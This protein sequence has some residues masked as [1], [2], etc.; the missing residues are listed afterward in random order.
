MERYQIIRGSREG[1]YTVVRKEHPGFMANIS[2][3]DGRMHLV[4]I[5][6]METCELT[7]LQV[8]LNEI[9]FYFKKEISEA[10]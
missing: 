7:V 10:S 8:A 2:F 3:V 4:K 6:L 9:E 1:H 5:T